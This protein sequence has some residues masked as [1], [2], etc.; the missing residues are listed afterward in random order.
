MDRRSLLAAG[1]A[2]LISPLTHAQA[3]FPSR[4]ITIYGALPAAGVMDQHLIEL[5]ERAQKTLGQA[6]V[7]EAKPGAGATLAPQLIQAAAPDGHL[8]AAMT[9]NSLRYP[10]YQKT[11]YEPLKDFTFIIGLSNFT[12][13]IVVHADS[14]YKTIEDL[15]AAGKACMTLKFLL[16]VGYVTSLR[17]T[18][19]TGSVDCGAAAPP[20][21]MADR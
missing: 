2:A 12:F 5:A 14:P 10:Y 6:I 9:V 8:L 18:A 15:I 3:R 21:A 11:T 16:P 19:S 13:G 17:R 7:I 20:L 1:A 4:S